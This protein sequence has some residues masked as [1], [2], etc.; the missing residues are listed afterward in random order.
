MKNTNKNQNSSW[1]ISSI[2]NQTKGG[3][4]VFFFL[5]EQKPP[6]CSRPPRSL[7]DSEGCRMRVCHSRCPRTSKAANG[8]DGRSRL[9]G[10]LQGVLITRRLITGKISWVLLINLWPDLLIGQC[11]VS[12]RQGA[13][14]AR[15]TTPTAAQWEADQ[16]SLVIPPISLY[17][18]LSAFPLEA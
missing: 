17:L 7:S 3:C 1:E 14:T 5:E 4:Y 6:K 9:S 18:P 10:T 13:T 15:L 8:G 16:T 11:R 2:A 12:R